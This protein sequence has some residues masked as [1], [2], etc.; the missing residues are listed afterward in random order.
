[1]SYIKSA[2]LMREV[3]ARL[4]SKD[5][6]GAA[7]QMELARAALKANSESLSLVISML[8]G[9]P[10]MD[11][12][13]KSF[14]DPGVKR[15]ID[16]LA[17]A[18][19]HKVLFRDTNAAKQQEIKAMAVRQSELAIRCQKLSEV[20]EPHALL[21]AATA[22]LITAATTMQSSDQDAVKRSQKIVM[23]TLRYF[24]IEQALA[25]ETASPPPAAIIGDP[26]AAG[27]GSDAENTYKAGLI[28]DF[29][30]GEAPK[31]KR[32]E[33]QVRAD[34]NRAALN[35][36]FAR[37]LPLEYRGLLKNYYERVAK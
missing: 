32:S 28:S 2:K 19:A 6:A 18:N 14:T 4:E 16:V 35:Q 26:L 11:T 7:E 24:I 20:G 15:L 3:L 13:L 22:Q 23:Q 27:P 9:L 21:N 36:N 25:L 37:E 17:V 31:D 29:V 33:W 34:R 1:M 5:A 8:H 12:E 10:N 30:S